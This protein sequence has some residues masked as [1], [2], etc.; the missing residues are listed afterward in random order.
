MLISV[1][2]SRFL[3]AARTAHAAAAASIVAQRSLCTTSTDTPP[4]PERRP[5]DGVR[6]LEMGQLI[7]GPFTGTMLAYFGAEVIK[8]ETP[9]SGDQLRKCESKLCTLE[10]A[11]AARMPRA[12]TRTYTHT[13]QDTKCESKLCTLKHAPAARMPT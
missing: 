11:P 6:V 13:P 4:P 10:H 2:G 3:V 7:A 5:L 1:A 12:H 9:G 8:I